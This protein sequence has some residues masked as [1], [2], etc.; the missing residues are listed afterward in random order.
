MQKEIM[1]ALRKI[2]KSEEKILV[3]YLLAPTLKN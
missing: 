1:E 3:A 2:F